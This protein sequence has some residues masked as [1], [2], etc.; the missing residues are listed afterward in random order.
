MANTCKNHNGCWLIGYTADDV[1]R[2]P[3]TWLQGEF[4]GGFTSSVKIKDLVQLEM[5]FNHCF[6]DSLVI[7]WDMFHVSVCCHDLQVFGMLP[8]FFQVTCR[9]QVAMEL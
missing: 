4:L 8:G 6:Q 2:H 5:I 3:N 7:T 9:L 1:G